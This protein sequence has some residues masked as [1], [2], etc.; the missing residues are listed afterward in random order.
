MKKKVRLAYVEVLDLN[1]RLDRARQCTLCLAIDAP[2][3]I[4]V[5]GV[6]S[7]GSR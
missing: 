3:I 6:S 5:R 1:V 7:T 2:G 4:V